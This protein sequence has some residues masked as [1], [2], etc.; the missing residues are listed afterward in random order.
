MERV[1]LPALGRDVSRVALGT[2]S[3]G[4]W[5]WGGAD[6]DAA[7]ATIERALDLGIDIIDTAPVYGFGL[8]E[9][10]LGGIID[11]RGCREQVV[12]ATKLGLSWDARHE[13]WRDTSAERI[14]EEVVASLARL[15]TDYIDIYQVHWPD[16]SVPFEETAAELRML[17]D[18]GLVRAI[19][20]CNY[21]VEQ[22]ESFCPG[23]RLDTTQFRYN[24]FERAAEAD[25]LPFS[26]ER[27]LATMAYSPLAR[28]LLSGSMKP[29]HEATDH[30]RRGEMFHGDAYA[31]HLSAV[32]R[33]D[34]FAQESYGRRVIHLAMRWLLD[35]PGLTIALW[36]AR[37]PEQLEAASG[38]EGFTLDATAMTEIDR[39][40]AEELGD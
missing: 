3:M 26:R 27:G 24:L 2:W 29:G 17:V 12:I 6:K 30:A 31:K 13:P 37:K 35:Q 8:S 36:G 22:M 20:V 38:V 11:E 10:L 7:R 40:L 16:V 18:E 25:V 5:M 15:R 14:R 9:E 32:A 23:G 19:G 33:L 39:I 4:G 34:A 21:S 1:W 28:G